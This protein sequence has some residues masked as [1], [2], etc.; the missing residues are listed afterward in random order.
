MR[1]SRR[2]WIGSLLVAST[3]AAVVG[4]TA[5]VARAAE[6]A[7]AKEQ[8]TL[9]AKVIGDDLVAS[10]LDKSERLCLVRAFRDD[11]PLAATVSRAR[12]LDR[13]SSA[14]LVKVIQMLT[15][16]APDAVAQEFM[17]AADTELVFEEADPEEVRCFAEEFVALDDAILLA[18]LRDEEFESLSTDE[19]VEFVTMMFDCMPGTM[20]RVVVAGVAESIDLERVAPTDEQHRCVGASVTT[21]VDPDDLASAIANEEPSVEAS[22]GLLRAVVSC[23][24]VVMIEVFTES[25]VDNGVPQASAR[26]IASRIVAEPALLELI[27]AAEA[28]G[29]G[30][31]PPEVQAVAAAC[32]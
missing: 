15:A 1:A 26:C 23:A 17:A 9:A 16:C 7:S 11:K 29:S 22:A 5:P 28:S 31:I 3:V 14:K 8:A 18:A 10:S 24:P 25:F 20:G 21:A 19:Q 6:G 13:L 32:A 12:D 27:I 2:T 30:V 4:G